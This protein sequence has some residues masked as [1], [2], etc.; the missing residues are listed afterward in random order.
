M[1]A[2][3][4]DS[5]Q[6]L[7]SV[8]VDGPDPM[9]ARPNVAIQSAEETN[10]KTAKCTKQGY[11]R[12]RYNEEI[13]K[14]LEVLYKEYKQVRAELGPS[15]HPPKEFRNKCLQKLN[16]TYRIKEYE[17]TWSRV[18]MWFDHQTPRKSSKPATVDQ[19]PYLTRLSDP[20]KPIFKISKVPLH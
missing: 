17:W 13:V 9:L 20:T 10:K 14:E 15:K 7:S 3:S 2:I 4:G 1:R 6:S 5:D 11:K 19:S 12:E 18:Y 16:E 8:P